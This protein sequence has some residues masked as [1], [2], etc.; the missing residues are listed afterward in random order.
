M[1]FSLKSLFKYA[2]LFNTV[3]F[4]L[5]VQLLGVLWLQHDQTLLLQFNRIL[6]FSTFTSSGMAFFGIRNTVNFFCSKLFKSFFL[7]TSLLLLIYAFFLSA[8]FLQ[9]IC[10]IFLLICYS[11]EG[12]YVHFSKNVSWLMG[13]EFF[14]MTA[15]TLLFFYSSENVSFDFIIPSIALPRV[16]LSF[17]L[18]F[19]IESSE[20]RTEVDSK[21][22]GLQYFFSGGNLIYLNL[23]FLFSTV[24]VY[25]NTV[26]FRSVNI[27]NRLFGIISE[28]Y[29]IL[30]NG[31]IIVQNVLR[32]RKT[33]L[34]ILTLF[35][36]LVFLFNEQTLLLMI[37]LVGV[38]YFKK[39]ITDILRNNLKYSQIM[40]MIYIQAL[41]MFVLFLF[42]LNTDYL[43]FS[44]LIFDIIFILYFVLRWKNV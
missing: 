44:Y 39:I 32:K 28:R 2:V 8:N 13:L 12:L 27:I 22:L 23:P 20:S 14:L 24:N 5:Y 25:N 3:I 19:Q 43:I 10:L 34:W 38:R 40:I 16:I 21:I 31:G 30:R 15:F 41:L 35:T 36:V 11:T 42:S 17:I 33:V 26:V 7:F 6:F 1:T 9:V 18:F 37:M 29:I 4:S